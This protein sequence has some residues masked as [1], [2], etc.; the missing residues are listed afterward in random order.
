M[1]PVSNGAS[2]SATPAKKKGILGIFGGKVESKGNVK[3]ET[4]GAKSPTKE[5]APKE[6]SKEKSS[7][8]KTTTKEE[9]A[10]P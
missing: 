3:E 7:K 4:K 6:K 10:R 5:Q 9:A 1:D 8:E 2:A